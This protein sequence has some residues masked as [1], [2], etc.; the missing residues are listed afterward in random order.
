MY[1]GRGKATWEMSL[2]SYGGVRQGRGKAQDCP[3]RYQG[4]YEDVETGLY[5]NRFRYYDPEV[6]Q[7]ISQDPVKIFGG[8][9][10]Y[11]YLSNPNRYIDP[12][13][14]SGDD[15]IH[16]IGGNSAENFKLKPAEMK[17]NPPGISVL[18]GGSPQDAAKQM[19][20]VFSDPKYTKLQESTKTVAS[21]TIEQIEGTGFKVMSDPTKN[22]PNHHRII[23]PEGVEG[24]SE[25]NLKRL[26]SVFK[27]SPCPK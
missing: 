16:R 18:K 23:H 22:F 1:D 12:Y 25:E 7:Y 24:F 3:F 2:D 21:S 4:Q 10:L 27:N 9:N 15:P 14:L 8:L 20:D 17:L 19:R 5:Y 11:G 6:G 13:G 26:Q